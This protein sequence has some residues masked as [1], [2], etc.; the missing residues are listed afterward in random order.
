MIPSS[1][2]TPS[3]V[4]SLALA[5][6][7]FAEIAARAGRSKSSIQ[8]EIERAKAG[9]IVLP[10]KPTLRAT[11]GASIGRILND[12]SKPACTLA[13]LA[14]KYGF[15]EKQ[16]SAAIS[17]AR[18]RG[19]RRA[20]TK[21]QKLR[22]VEIER[23]RRERE[24]RAKADSRITRAEA[25]GIRILEAVFVDKSVRLADGSFAKFV[26]SLSGGDDNWNLLARHFRDEEPIVELELLAA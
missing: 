2:K 18:D 1:E 11:I 15:T 12:W 4:I 19:D 22:L 3:N 14:E 9:G 25:M 24:A 7:S 8:G 23:R 17:A 5:G 20:L 6:L 13:D 26:V 16:I 10:F 21:G